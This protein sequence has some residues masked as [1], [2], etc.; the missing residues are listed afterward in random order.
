MTIQTGFV[1]TATELVYLARSIGHGPLFG[2][3]DPFAALD[4]ADRGRLTAEVEN[5][6][7]TNKL[8]SPSFDGD[9]I[10]NDNLANLLDVCTS[11]SYYIGF[12]YRDGISVE[13]TER[14]YCKGS[15]WA[16]I[17]DEEDHFRI[18]YCTSDMVQKAL[19]QLPST[20]GTEETEPRMLIQRRELKEVV[21]LL[22]NNQ[23]E[24]ASLMLS[25][26]QVPASTIELLIAEI[27][28]KTQFVSL[29]L[30]T[31]VSDGIAFEN[32]SVIV[33]DSIMGEFYQEVA[34]DDRTM[35]GLRPAVKGV[36]TRL[37][38]VAEQWSTASL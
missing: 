21:R 25:E 1:L 6:L 13:K 16:T 23:T 7:I 35:I 17:Q 2:V 36:Y 14:F 37:K 3:S 12:D 31:P 30:A 24:Q 18:S 11:F 20:T 26:K 29:S 19:K 5:T 38:E 9:P 22:R 32:V 34:D 28:K 8:C 33:K 4:G 27:Q 15:V 10:C